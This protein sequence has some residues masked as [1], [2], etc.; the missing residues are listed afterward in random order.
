MSVPL[1][2]NVGFTEVTQSLV[3]SNSGVLNDIAGSRINLPIQYFKLGENISGNLTLNNVAN[4]KKIILDTDGKT[5]LNPS[6]S[7]LTQNSSVAMELKGSGNIQSTLKTS[8]GTQASTSYSG[9]TTLS[10]SNSSTVVV[11]DDGFVL[12]FNENLTLSGE[13]YRDKYTGPRTADNIPAGETFLSLTGTNGSNITGLTANGFT[14][15]NTGTLATGATGTIGSFAFY[16]M[17]NASR[18][19]SDS[20]WKAYFWCSTG[21]FKKRVANNTTV[22]STSSPDY[23]TEPGYNPYT[24]QS[25]SPLGSRDS[26]NDHNA[27][28]NFSASGRVE[29]ITVNA[30]TLTFTNNLSISCVLSGADP[31]DGVTV[32]A[33]A[34]TQKILYNTD[35]SFN[36]TMT[37]SGNNDSGLPLALADVNN[38]TGSLDT[39]T[40]GYTGTFSA[41]AFS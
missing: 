8:T 41:K 37:I 39:S 25:Y 17:T 5:L 15:N 30:R 29:N 7:P 10:N 38:G 4:N 9:T 12:T 16:R 14:F 23:I 27:Y 18:T 3:D 6:G 31:F 26:N 40:Q 11:G 35:G 34:T 2:S 20:A 19:R 28:G 13:P 21:M 22:S 24:G 33:G 36:I 32:N 1:V